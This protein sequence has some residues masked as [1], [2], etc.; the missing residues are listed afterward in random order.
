VWQYPDLL[1]GTLLVG[2][3]SL[4]KGYGKKV[5]IAGVVVGIG[6]LILG[7]IFKSS[8]VVLLAFFGQYL[9]LHFWLAF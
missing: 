4:E 6:F 1:N 9:G 7:F 2:R 8:Y 3:Y 5:A